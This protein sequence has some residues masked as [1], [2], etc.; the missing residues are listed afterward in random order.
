[1]N[2]LICCV[3]G[4]GILTIVAGCA[5]DG[6]VDGAIQASLFI[7]NQSVEVDSIP[8]SVELDGTEIV[9]ADFPAV[10]PDGGIPQHYWVRYDINMTD[11]THYLFASTDA[12]GGAT[13]SE[14]LDL[15]DVGADDTVYLLLEFFGDSAE[16]GTLNLR[17]M[18]HEPSS[19]EC[20]SLRG[21]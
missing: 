15:D 9:N 4:T 6:N 3:I 21:A 10:G 14:T 18:D 5:S 7:S 19:S 17:I 1:M 20:F 13:M 12:S 11:E 16:T 2:R 8:I